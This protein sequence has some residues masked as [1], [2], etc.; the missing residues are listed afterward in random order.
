MLAVTYSDTRP[1][2]TL[3]YRLLSNQMSTSSSLPG[4]W[5]HE[6]TRHLSAELGTE[7]TIREE[8]EISG[9]NLYQMGQQGL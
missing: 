7:F 1:R 3:R 2:E 9:E 5:G 6:Y 4:L 8:T